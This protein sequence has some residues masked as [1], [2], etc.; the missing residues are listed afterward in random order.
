MYEFEDGLERSEYFYDITKLK[1]VNGMHVIDSEEKARLE[2]K[3]IEL[4]E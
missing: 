1:Q 4:Y 2:E 3:Q